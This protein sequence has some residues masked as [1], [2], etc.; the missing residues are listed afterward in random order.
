MAKD[1]FAAKLGTSLYIAR[2]SIF[3]E[4]WLDICNVQ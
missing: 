3:M 4:T 2:I 1:V